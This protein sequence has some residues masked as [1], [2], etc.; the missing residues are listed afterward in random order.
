MKK[1]VY[2]APLLVEMEMEPSGN[3]QAT[4][5]AEQINVDVNDPS[6]KVDAGDALVSPFDI[7]DEGE[8]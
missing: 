4:S 6:E 7:R 1:Y 3:L 8:W 2:V 5:L